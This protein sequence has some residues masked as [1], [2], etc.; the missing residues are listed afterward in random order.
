[1]TK[2]QRRA[3]RRAAQ[4]EQFKGAEGERNI[5]PAFSGQPATALAEQLAG[6][7]IE[8]QTDVADTPPQEEEGIVLSPLE[9]L[10]EVDHTVPEEEPQDEAYARRLEE[11]ELARAKAAAKLV[12]VEVP[13]K[14]ASPNIP[15]PRQE[16]A[17]KL[18]E[19]PKVETKP[20]SP[21]PKTPKVV[22]TQEQ[23]GPTS[24]EGVM[25][26]PVMDTKGRIKH[27]QV[28]FVE[29]G[30]VN[31]FDY[32]AEDFPVGFEVRP[33][34]PVR[35][36]LK[37][38]AGRYYITNLGYVRDAS[39]EQI[40]TKATAAL[41][42]AKGFGECELFSQHRIWAIVRQIAAEYKE[43]FLKLPGENILAEALALTG[44]KYMGTNT[45]RN[46]EIRH[47]LVKEA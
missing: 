12:K 30:K 26:E 35:F 27:V 43:E 42:E 16:K 24:F 6:I 25:G 21:P 10:T 19:Q 40:L 23:T 41:D 38:P 17:R 32:L 44:Y 34:A 20:T 8:N 2:K 46:G 28:S 37:K 4:Q 29:G 3:A 11:L 13:E 7:I 22:A 14:K 31:A 33:G 45:A 47:I 18:A 15:P 36:Q 39:M 5:S 9:S 1:M